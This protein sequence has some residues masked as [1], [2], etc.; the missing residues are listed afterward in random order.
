MNNLSAIGNV[1]R[2]AEVRF[3][4]DQTPV[5]SF[6]FA[7]SS[8]YGDKRTTTWLNCSLFGKRAETIAPMLTKGTQ[9]GLNGE[10]SQRVYKDKDGVEKSSL[11]LRVNDITLLGKKELSE[12]KEPAK[13]NAYQPDPM[14]DFEDS[15]PF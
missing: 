12:A 15:I 11:D 9:I 13:A 14:A 1:G 4:P 3:L 8:G 10:F 7:L 5:A 6:S 2:D